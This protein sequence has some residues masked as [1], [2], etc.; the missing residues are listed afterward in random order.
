MKK[1]SMLLI[2][3]GF[4]GVGVLM[5]IRDEPVVGVLGL[6]MGV[7]GVGAYV[8]E[9]AQLRGD[10]RAGG[11]HGAG[12]GP[13]LLIAIAV[14]GLGTLA[15]AL[16]IIFASSFTERVYRAPDTPTEARIYGAVIAA[17]CLLGVVVGI[18]RWI[19]SS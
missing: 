9:R 11:L 10:P 1:F 3:A 12:R 6:I 15:G 14:A 2:A 7:A 5:L 17:V 19:R 18:R 4:F 8:I 16:L 13:F